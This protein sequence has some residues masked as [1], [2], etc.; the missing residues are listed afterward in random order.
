MLGVV[1]LGVELHA[2][3]APALVADGHIGAGIGMGHQGKALR[4]LFH[5]V[6]VAHPGN[7]LGRQA[8]EKLAVGVE[9]RLGLAV[10]PGGVVRGRHHP[11][12]Q[13][14]G[15]QLAAVADAQ[16]GDAQLEDLRIGLGRLGIVYAVG[17]AGEDDADGVQGLDIG[18]GRGVGLD[19]AV[20]IALPDAP[21]D[22]LVILS[23]EVNDQNHL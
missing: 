3:E 13:V 11:A 18:Q 7:A 2:V 12:A 1:H 19:L 21:G 20:H 15:Q 14:V 22:E 4:H 8:L 9:I 16:D 6:A 10:L 23:A 5:I 17:T